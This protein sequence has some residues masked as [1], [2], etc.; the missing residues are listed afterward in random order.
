MIP[1]KKCANTGTCVGKALLFH[2]YGSCLIAIICYLILNNPIFAKDL[3][4]EENGLK[5]KKS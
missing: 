4:G 2:H 3:Q 1:K 5:G